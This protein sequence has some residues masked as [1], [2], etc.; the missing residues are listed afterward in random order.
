MTTVIIIVVH[1]IYMY[2]SLQFER[3]EKRTSVLTGNDYTLE[4]LNSQ[5]LDRVNRIM[6]M[7]KSTFILLVRELKDRNLLSLER[8]DITVGATIAPVS[9]YSIRTHE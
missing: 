3:Q 7:Q 8:K 9:T 2:Y 6:R 5:N 1:T 4:L